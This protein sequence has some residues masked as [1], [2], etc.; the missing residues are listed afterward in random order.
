M[1]PIGNVTDEDHSRENASSRDFALAAPSRSHRPM[2]PMKQY[3]VLRKRRLLQH[4]NFLA[5][6]RTLAPS[7][8][9]T[10]S[11]DPACCSKANI[12]NP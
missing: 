6:K 10:K 12:K 5:A 1:I 3:L 2:L 4:V 7:L 8:T 9:L 11:S